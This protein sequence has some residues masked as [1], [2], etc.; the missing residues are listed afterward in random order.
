MIVLA[1]QLPSTCIPLNEVL[2]VNEL[3]CSF[4]IWL[5]NT[6]IIKHVLTI[7]LL[8]LSQI[9]LLGNDFNK[10]LLSRTKPISLLQTFCEV[11]L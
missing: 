9:N 10:K 7:L 8:F 3:C 4:E 6:C 11:T 1:F 5:I 2:L